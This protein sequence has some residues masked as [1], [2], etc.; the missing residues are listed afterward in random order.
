MR[1]FLASL[2]QRMSSGESLKG[3][4]RRPGVEIEDEDDADAFESLAMTEELR[5][6]LFPKT[7]Q[8]V[9]AIFDQPGSPDRMGPPPS[10]PPR[11]QF[12]GGRPS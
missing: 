8:M 9:S 6:A 11:S 5:E 1:K 10:D 4:A 2:L 3:A 12:G 7:T